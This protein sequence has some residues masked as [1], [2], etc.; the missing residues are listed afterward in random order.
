MKTIAQLNGVE[1]LKQCNKIRYEVADVL[2]ATNIGEIRS[3]LP[4][5]SKC[6]TKEEREALK[7]EQAV[8]NMNDILDVLLEEKPEETM[9][10]LNLLIIRED[11]DAE[12]TGLE[13]AMIGIGIVSD[14]RV[15]DFLLSLIQLGQ[16]VTVL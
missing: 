10:L 6:T 7:N 3:R 14:K 1:F 4:D 12:I 5:Y 13:L 16:K 15:A 8:K 9:K 11:G 2:K